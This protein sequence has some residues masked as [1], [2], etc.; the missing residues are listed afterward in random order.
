[1]CTEDL[2]LFDLENNRT[3]FFFD[4]LIAFNQ[5]YTVL[6]RYLCI[7]VCFFGVLLNCLHFYVL[8]QKA[9]RVYIINA[10]LC[11]MSI[12]DIITMASYFV[13]ILRFRIFDSSNVIGYTYPWLIFLITHVTSSIALHTTSLYLSVIMAYIR[14]TALDRLDAKWINHG[15]LKRIFILTAL[16]VSIISIPTVM[17]HKIVTVKDILHINDTNSQLDG[18]YTVTL[19]ETKINGCALFRLNLWITGIMFKALP[20]I[21]ILWFTIALIYKLCEM[22]EKRKLLR[23]ENNRKAEYPLVAPALNPTSSARDEQ[24]NR[25]ISHA[26]SID[27]TTLMLIIMLVVFLCT[28]LPQGLLAILSAIYPTHVHTMIY[29]NVGEVLDLL[30][31]INCLTSFVVY[32]VMSTTY[33]ATVNKMTKGKEDEF[34]D[35][36]HFGGRTTSF[37]DNDLANGL[38]N[39]DDNIDDLGFTTDGEQNRHSTDKRLKNKRYNEILEKQHFDMINERIVDDVSMEVFYKPHSIT[40]LLVLSIGLFYKAFNEDSTSNTEKNIID[41]FMGM[42]ALFLMISALTFP[43]G[44]FIR[45]HPVVWRIIFGLSVVYVLILQFALFQTHDDLKKLLTWLD[46]VGLGQ[47]KLEEKEYAQDCWNF[48]FEKIMSHVDFF[49]FS[50]FVGWVMKAVLIRHWVLSWYI[51]IIWEFTELMFMALLPNFA[52]CWWDAIILDVLIC[53]GLGIYCGM[54]FCKFLQMRIYHWESVRNIKSR[55]GKMKRLALQFT[56]ASWSQ[57][58]WC[59]SNSFGQAVKRTITLTVFVLFWLI[60]ELNTFFIKHIFAIDT[61]HPVVFWR[62]ILIGC[63]AAPT[64]RQFYVYATDPLTRRVGM[65]CWIFVLICVLEMAVC[66]KC[67]RELFLQIDLSN[68]AIW[69]STIIITTIFCIFVSIWYAE[70]FE[71]TER[72]LVKG[73]RRLCYLESSHENLGILQDDVVKRRKEYLSKSPSFR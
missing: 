36:P 66:V 60:S 32:C 39:S 42:L 50:H 55:R 20:C 15:A 29:V 2:P 30:S 41:G 6:H 31:L 69:L 7:F 22:S 38:I 35:E 28:E 73:R 70:K 16:I 23:G 13:Y 48:S 4:Q 27:R 5:V 72:V 26:V 19:D 11:A 24:K 53:N 25:K 34:D 58:E 67:A 51:S 9:M 64:I 37:S 33:R 57:F 3:Q 1:M 18:L 63:I 21:L 68:I 65:Q 40:L 61:Q 46:P 52:E 44:P 17:V 45:P 49:A 47:K 59:Y 12:C 43:N 10:L 54:K 56:P 62:I 8:M 71:K 14:W